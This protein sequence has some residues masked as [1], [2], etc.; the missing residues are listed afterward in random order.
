MPRN[1]Q[2]MLEEKRIKPYWILSTLLNSVVIM[3]TVF[4]ALAISVMIITWNY[5]QS[6]L[7]FC[8]RSGALIGVM[9]FFWTGYSTSWGRKDEE[10]EFEEDYSVGIDEDEGAE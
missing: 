6:L 10:P 2:A 4:V 3:I 1:E 9:L 7:L 5:N 8:V